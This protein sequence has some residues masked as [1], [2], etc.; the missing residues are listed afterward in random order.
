MTILPVDGLDHQHRS[1]LSCMGLRICFHAEVGRVLV[2]SRMFEDGEVVIYSRVTTFNVKED[3]EVFAL[4]DPA[5][6]SCC[7]VLVPRLRKLYYNKET[8]SH[9]DPVG[10]GDLWYL[11][12][13]SSR[14][15]VEVMLRDSGIQFRAKR[16]IQ[17]NEAIVWM[18]PPSFFATDENAVDLPVNIIPDSTILPRE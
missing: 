7:Y 8:F 16:T 18:Y 2:S 6:P 10:S 12:N 15:N 3:G 9:I 5:H 1:Q 14:P 17:P 4:L 13:H 11:V